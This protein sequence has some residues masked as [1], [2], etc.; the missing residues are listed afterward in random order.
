MITIY[1]NGIYLVLV[2]ILEETELN[3]EKLFRFRCQAHVYHHHSFAK[4][5]VAQEKLICAQWI[6]LKTN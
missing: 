3:G 5:V 1:R 2:N 4:N 6:S